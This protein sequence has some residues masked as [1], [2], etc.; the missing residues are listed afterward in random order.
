MI[1]VLA[2][3]KGGVGKTTTALN[4][5]EILKPD[6]II[7]QDTHNN[8]VILNQLRDEK[9]QLNVLSNLNKS[10]LINALSK[11]AQGQLILVD[12]GGFD[13]ELNRIAIAASDMTIVPANDDIN[14]VVGLK[15]FNKT[16]EQISN[17]MGEKIT[18]HVM[19]TRVHPSRKKFTDVESFINNSDNLARL[20][21]VIPT[22][23]W[24][25]MAALDGY[26]V[27]NHK[28]TKYS[29][30]AREV[31]ALATEIKTRLNIK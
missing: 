29:D 7:D 8:L 14:E 10:E 25:A 1:I 21:T 13:S 3:D 28:K 12:C 2:H 9:D 30:A 15:R 27:T 19:F 23:K 11:S 6:I 16:L 17:D 24:H 4:L 20:Q 31:T 5:A 22:R 18:G 26:G